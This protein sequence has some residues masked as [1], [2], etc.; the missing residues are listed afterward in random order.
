M[1]MDKSYRKTFALLVVLVLGS[2][3]ILSGCWPMPDKE[4][5]DVDDEQTQERE[6]N[7]ENEDSDD[8]DT[9]DVDTEDEDTVDEDEDSES[10]DDEDENEDEDED[11]GPAVEDPMEFSSSSQ[12]LSGTNTAGDA[13][14]G[15]YTW[16]ISGDVLKFAWNTSAVS[17][18]PTP[19]TSAVYSS[20]AD[21][22]TVTFSNVEKDYLAGAGNFE[23]DLSG[24]VSKVTGS[25]SGNSYVYVFEL[26]KDT[27][28][29]IYRSDDPKDSV[30]IEVKR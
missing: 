30:V 22:I 10:D 16:S 6:V 8:V 15:T 4:E 19:G 9:G 3:F 27:E 29:R 12:T 26:T 23:A 5:K 17:G 25:K 28:Y 20:S 21:T 13:R 24:P 1:K 2:G 7:D 18:N 11:S 14:I